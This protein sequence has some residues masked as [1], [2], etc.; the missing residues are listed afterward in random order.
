MTTK[1]KAE[2]GAV[3]SVAGGALVVY[4]VQDP[5]LRASLLTGL[6]LLTGWLGFAKPGQA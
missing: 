4:Y 1:T 2:I 5:A 6:G 3:L